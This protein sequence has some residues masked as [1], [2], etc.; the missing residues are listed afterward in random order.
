MVFIFEFE[1]H[2]NTS[3]CIDHIF[4]FYNMIV[5]LVEGLLINFISN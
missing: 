1:L 2:I 4:L 3:R 5:Y